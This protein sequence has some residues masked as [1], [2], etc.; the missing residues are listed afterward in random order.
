[1][2]LTYSLERAKQIGYNRFG[3]LFAELA[4]ISPLRLVFD[5]SRFSELLQD[6]AKHLK[7]I[8]RPTDTISRFGEGPF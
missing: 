6:T 1:M 8:L 3:V 2:R 4:P 7:T 5:D